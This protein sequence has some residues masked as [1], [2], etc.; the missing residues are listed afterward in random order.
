VVAGLLIAVPLLDSAPKGGF[1]P[2][3]VAASEVCTSDGGP[4]VC[5]TKVHEAGLAALTGPARRALTLLAKV[6]DAPTSVH[7]VTANRPGPQP[8]SEVWFHS[9]NYQAGQGWLSSGDELVVRILAGG[10]TRPC[11]DRNGEIDYR[12]RSLVGAWLYGQ[13]PAPGPKAMSGE[14][15]ARD[16]AWQELKALPPD[17][18]LRRITAARQEGLTCDATGVGAP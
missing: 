7:E 3:L 17:E 2:D 4:A 10:G 12:S 8:A 16:A 18:Q 6:P 13:Y 5:V 11:T 14:A 1:E 15:T 9:D